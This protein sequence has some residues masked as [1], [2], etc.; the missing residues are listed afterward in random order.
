MRSNAQFYWFFALL[1]QG[2]A[3]ASHHALPKFR[4][5]DSKTNFRR[6]AAKLAQKKIRIKE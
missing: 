2:L 5:N 3:C 1:L 4:F 6:Q